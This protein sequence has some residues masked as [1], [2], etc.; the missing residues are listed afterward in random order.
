MVASIEYSHFDGSRPLKEV[1]YHV[2]SYETQFLRLWPEAQKTIMFDDIHATSINSD[3]FIS[4]MQ[5]NLSLT[6][7]CIYP[8]SA[9]SALIQKVYKKLS[10]DGYTFILEDGKEYIEQNRGQYNEQS[11]F[12][13]KSYNK[14]GAV[15]SC[16]ALVAASYLYK[17]SYFDEDIKGYK[18]TFLQKSSDDSI[19]SILPSKYLQVEENAR[20]II[21]LIKPELL[22]RLRYIFY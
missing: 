1:I 17:L 5:E 13:L 22:N 21:R 2:N 12:L 9:F 11:R 8:E 19:L 4:Q 20:T 7:D 6:P 10:S 14:S 18:D 3:D 16:P 15:F